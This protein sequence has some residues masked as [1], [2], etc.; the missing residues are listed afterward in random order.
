MRMLIEKLQN[1]IIV[2]PAI[3]CLVID[4]LRM[5][6]SKRIVMTICKLLTGATLPAFSSWYARL[7]QTYPTKAQKLI[8]KRKKTA[9]HV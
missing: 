1:R 9:S 7:A 6:T 5:I 2:I 4:C 3:S 8:M